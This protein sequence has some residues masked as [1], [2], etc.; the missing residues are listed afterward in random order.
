MVYCHKCSGNKSKVP[1][2]EEEAIRWYARC[3]KTERFTSEEFNIFWIKNIEK[4]IDNL[5]KRE[6][7]ELVWN[8]A[9]SECRIKLNNSLNK[10][11]NK[12]EY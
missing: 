9:I 5:S 6:I 4:E 12:K 11:L 10:Y 2:S 3:R 7:A 1:L 8:S